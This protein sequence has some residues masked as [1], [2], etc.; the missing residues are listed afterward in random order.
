MTSKDIAANTSVRLIVR[1]NVSNC[2]ERD[3]PRSKSIG[4]SFEEEEAVWEML[5]KTTYR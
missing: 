1:V 3:E 4:A 2:T 5:L